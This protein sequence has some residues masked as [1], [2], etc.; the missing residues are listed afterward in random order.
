[1]Q[2]G[3]KIERVRVMQ[4]KSFPEAK[5]IVL[6]AARNVPRTVSKNHGSSSNY[7]N[8]RNIIDTGRATSNK[9][10]HSQSYRNALINEGNKVQI[11]QP[12]LHDL[13]KIIKKVILEIFELNLHEV[14]SE[15]REHVLDKALEKTRKEE[16]ILLVQLALVKVNLKQVMNLKPIL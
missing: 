4:N 12:E 16:E 10:V 13:F 15:S 9:K 1:M 7:N 14:Q 11:V 6:N 3:R 8:N 5:S 2:I